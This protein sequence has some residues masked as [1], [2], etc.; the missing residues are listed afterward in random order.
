MPAKNSGGDDGG[1]PETGLPSNRYSPPDTRRSTG[2]PA[3][4]TPA[5]L[6]MRSGQ[7][8]NA[9][10]PSRGQAEQP[11]PAETAIAVQA[12]VRRVRQGFAP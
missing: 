8:V 3:M 5:R 1:Q 10:R 7:V 9:V 11:Q 4:T 6:T 2:P 12:L